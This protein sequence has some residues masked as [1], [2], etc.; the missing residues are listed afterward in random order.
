MVLHIDAD[1]G[2]AEIDIGGDIVGYSAAQII[3]AVPSVVAD[4]LTRRTPSVPRPQA[5][6]WIVAALH[7]DQRPQSRGVEAAW[8]S[9]FYHSNSLGYIDNSHQSGRFRGPSTLSWYYPFD[10]LDISD[11]RKEAAMLDW[12]AVEDRVLTDLSAAHSNISRCVQAIDVHVWGH[13]TVRPVV[14]LHH[15]KTAC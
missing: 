8:D 15:P 14:G 1:T 11:A 9:V 7:A 10:A 12:W 6:P 13:G 4:R 2:D 5:S 3:L